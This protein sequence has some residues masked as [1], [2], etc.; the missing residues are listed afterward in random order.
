MHV[1]R[2]GQRISFHLDGLE[3]GKR[4]EIATMTPEQALALAADL[5]I[6]ADDKDDFEMILETKIWKGI[7]KIWKGI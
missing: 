4:T 6:V 3:H 2:N 7:C 5:V 1:E